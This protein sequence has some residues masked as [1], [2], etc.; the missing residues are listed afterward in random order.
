M[1]IIREIYHDY[2]VK[3][4]NRNIK[5]LD[6]KDFYILKDLEVELNSIVE[7]SYEISQNKYTFD[8]IVK[9]YKLRLKTLNSKKLRYS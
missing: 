5:P 4:E 8:D 2:K 7:I 6:P 9:C 3:C 1:N